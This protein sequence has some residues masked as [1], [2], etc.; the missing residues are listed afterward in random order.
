M[1][2][3]HDE[4]HEMENL[5][6]TE[7]LVPSAKLAGAHVF[8]PSGENIGAIKEVVLDRASGR[9]A[10]AVVGYGGFLGFG[11]SFHSLP[12]SQPQYD[13]TREGY[14]ADERRRSTRRGARLGRS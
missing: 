12:W 5:R 1:C 13:R 6:V 3:D 2:A 10:Y 11:K 4:E 14:V 7:D 9:A 8:D